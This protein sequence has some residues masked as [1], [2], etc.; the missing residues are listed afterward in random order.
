MKT[1]ILAVLAL[2][3]AA[4][5]CRLSSNCCDCSPPVTDGPYAAY[6]TMPGAQIPIGVLNPPLSPS[7][8]TPPAGALAPPQTPAEEE[9][10]EQSGK[11]AFQAEQ[12][13][14][15]PNTEPPVEPL[16]DPNQQDKPLFQDEQ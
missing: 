12:D 1:R 9:A 2:G 15:S 3:A 13:A 5:G 10:V 8:A 4:C 11:P 7:D 14:E 6:A 16:Y